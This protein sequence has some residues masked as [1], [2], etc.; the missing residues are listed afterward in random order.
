MNGERRKDEQITQ[1]R[2]RTCRRYFGTKENV[3]GGD[4]RHMASAGYMGIK[5]APFNIY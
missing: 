4:E 2:C 5:G 1:K 3:Y